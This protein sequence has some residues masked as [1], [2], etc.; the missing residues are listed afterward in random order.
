MAKAAHYE[1]LKELQQE[2][3]QTRQDNA[4]SVFAEHGISYEVRGHSW[5]CN[6]GHEAIYYWP[7]SGRWRVKGL[8]KTWG[9]R[10]AQDFL[11]KINFGKDDRPLNSLN[12]FDRDA[13]PVCTVIPI[14]D[15]IVDTA[16]I[17][18]VQIT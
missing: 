18:T 3:K 8:S 5:L 1:E 16:G 15:D 10:G 13:L 7:K 6:V 14:I 17:K 12:C 4:V 11:D 2:R 9:S